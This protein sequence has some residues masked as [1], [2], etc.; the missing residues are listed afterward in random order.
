[1]KYLDIYLMNKMIPDNIELILN[2]S[3]KLLLK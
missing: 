3:F 1:M 2:N